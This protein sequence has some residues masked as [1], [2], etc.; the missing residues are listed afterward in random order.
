MNVLQP[1]YNHLSL[2][3]PSLGGPVPLYQPPVPEMVYVSSE[4]T[5]RRPAARD[6]EHTATLMQTL[7][8]TP[9]T[10][11]TGSSTESGHSA[12]LLL[13]PSHPVPARSPQL[14]YA[15]IN[16]KQTQVQPPVNDDHVQYTQIEH[17]D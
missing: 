6:P 5:T 14:M 16:M 11:Q 15:Q 4:Q 1:C 12:D 17:Q 9:S 13:P 7:D 8:S 2:N 10:L 3:S